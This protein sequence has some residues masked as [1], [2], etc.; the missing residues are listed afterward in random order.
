MVDTTRTEQSQS[1][2]S[3]EPF[4]NFFIGRREI[5]QITPVAR[6]VERQAVLDF[7]WLKILYVPSVAQVSGCAVSRLNGSRDNFLYR[8]SHQ[9]YKKSF[10]SYN[11]VYVAQNAAQLK[12]DCAWHVCGMPG[13]ITHARAK[14]ALN[15]CPETMRRRGRP[16]RVMNSGKSGLCQGEGQPRLKKIHVYD[17]QQFN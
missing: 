3:W 12:W 15:W 16:R 13:P 4:F 9:T 6:R 1:F 11:S 17:V 2:C 10:A 7:S 14:I 5:H 8:M